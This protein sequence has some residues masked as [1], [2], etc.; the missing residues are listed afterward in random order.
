MEQT[1]SAIRETAEKFFEAC[2]SGRGWE[3]CKQYCRPDATFSAQAAALTGVD[4][5]EAYANWM[6]GMYAPLPNARYEIKSFAVDEQRNNVAAFGVFRAT[7]TAAGGPV[8]PTGKTVEADYVYV[9]DFEGSQIKHM[10]KIWNDAFSLKQL[11]WT[12]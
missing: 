7:H 4:T 10:T 6:K 3:G 11:G 5:V 2:E 8:A 1:I 9:M 12:A